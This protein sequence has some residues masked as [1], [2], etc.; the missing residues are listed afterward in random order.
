MRDKQGRL[1]NLRCAFEHTKLAC[2]PQTSEFV[3][4]M[5]NLSFVYIGTPIIFSS[6][7]VYIFTVIIIAFFV[8]L[9]LYGNT[10]WFFYRPRLIKML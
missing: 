7:F 9:M 6:N 10:I 1:V 3:F 8:Y 5:S 4:I 2:I